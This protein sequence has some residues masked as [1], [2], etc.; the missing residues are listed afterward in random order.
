MAEEFGRVLKAIHNLRAITE[1][2]KLESETEATKQEIAVFT[3]TVQSVFALFPS[4]CVPDPNSDE[5]T[6]DLDRLETAV[7]RLVGYQGLVREFLSRRLSCV[8]S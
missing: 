7:R 5:I 4:D 3:E 1:S 8:I 6:G 2:W